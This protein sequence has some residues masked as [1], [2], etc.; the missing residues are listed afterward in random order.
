NAEHT[1]HQEEANADAYGEH[2]HP[3]VDVRDVV[4]QYLQVRL[5]DGYRHAEY[6]AQHDDEPQLFRLGHA[7]AEIVAYGRHGRLRAQGEQTHAYYQEDDGDEKGQHQVGG[8]GHKEQ[9]QQ[10]HYERYRNHRAYRLTE[11]LSQD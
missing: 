9:A 2:Q 10:R 8:D 11:F 4:G 5:G 7:R 1:D 6:E 3:G